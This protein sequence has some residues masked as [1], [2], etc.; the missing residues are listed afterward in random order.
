MVTK[1]GSAAT[2]DFYVPHDPVYAPGFGPG[3]PEPKSMTRQEFAE[4]C[5][6][7]VLM[8]KYEKTGVWPNVP[9]TEP[10]YLDVSAVPDLMTAMQ[11]LED[12]ERA[13]MTLPAKV[14]R[15]FDNDPVKFVDFASS[16]DNLTQMRDWGL[17]PPVELPDADPTAGLVNGKPPLPRSPGASSVL[18]DHAGAVRGS[19]DR[20]AGSGS[21][22]G[23][24]SGS[25]GSSV[26]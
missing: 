19:S 3:D 10:V 9:G 8:A 5:D 4:E 15:E 26:T 23:G 14:R 7:N 16:K 25:T 20:G 21:T 11:Y 18:P 22:G 2:R 17:A 1:S 12:A 24:G 13:F 6:V